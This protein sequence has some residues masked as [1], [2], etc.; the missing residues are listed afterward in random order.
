MRIG[1]SPSEKDETV[2]N[3]GDGI[4]NYHKALSK[5]S[6]KFNNRGVK[7]RFLTRTEFNFTRELQNMNCYH[8]SVSDLSLFNTTS[9]LGNDATTNTLTELR[10]DSGGNA[11]KFLI[12][13]VPENEPNSTPEILVSRRP[14]QL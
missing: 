13:M 10:H 9:V 2:D 7:H 14:V 6:S 8:L 12:Y 5:I 11:I 3:N 4:D 1:S